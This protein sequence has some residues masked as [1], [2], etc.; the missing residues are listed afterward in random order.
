MIVSA[1]VRVRLIIRKYHNR[2][3]S[4][5]TAVVIRTSAYFRLTAAYR[6]YMLLEANAKR[7]R[8]ILLVRFPITL[9]IAE[10]SI[11]IGCGNDALPSSPPPFPAHIIISPNVGR[12]VLLQ[13]AVRGHRFGLL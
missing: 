7:R 4:H 8:D 12:C 6:R 9:K 11:A 5:R 10:I 1:R 3:V 2:I 13:P